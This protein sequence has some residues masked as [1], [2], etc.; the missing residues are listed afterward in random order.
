MNIPARSEL[1]LGPLHLIVTVMKGNFESDTLP[2]PPTV[3]GDVD[4]DWCKAPPILRH[5]SVPPRAFAT[6]RFP[7]QVKEI[8]QSRGPSLKTYYIFT[9]E[10]LPFRYEVPSDIPQPDQANKVRHRE[11][12]RALES[13]MRSLEFKPRPATVGTATVIFIH[14]AAWEML[15]YLPGFHDRKTHIK[16]WFF[17]Y[18]QHHT[19]HPRLWGVRE[20]F[21]RGKIDSFQAYTAKQEKVVL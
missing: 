1:R 4:Y 18:G 9:A 5:S 7:V 10:G 2:K 12:T 8:L 17:C 21:K 6:L 16:K 11:E 15:K 13:I 3:S 14:N 19:L 20:V